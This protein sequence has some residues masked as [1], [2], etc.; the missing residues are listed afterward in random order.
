[1]PGERVHPMCSHRCQ[2]VS[3]HADIVRYHLLHVVAVPVRPGDASSHAM[4]LRNAHTHTHTHTHT[5]ARTHVRTHTRAGRRQDHTITRVLSTRTVTHSVDTD[6]AA[7]ALTHAGQT[8]GIAE[9]R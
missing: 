2:H 1:M 8:E 3:S 6:H 4:W 5:H 7:A 9:G